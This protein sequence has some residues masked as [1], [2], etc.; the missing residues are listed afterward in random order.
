[1]K[2]ARVLHEHCGEWKD[3]S[4]IMVPDE[5]TAPEFRAAVDRAKRAL[6]EAITTFE[7]NEGGQPPVP[8]FFGDITKEEYANFTIARYLALVDERKRLRQDW[9]T[10][11]AA[12]VASFTEYLLQEITPSCYL[13]EAE[14]LGAS[15]MWGHRHAQRI[16]PGGQIPKDMTGFELMEEMEEDQR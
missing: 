12:T 11:R 9:E 3:V 6:L 5:L 4:Y 13:H 8:N 1:M 7:L 10:R 14:C 16:R 2:L 15:V